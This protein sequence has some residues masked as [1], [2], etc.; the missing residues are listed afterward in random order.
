VL[1]RVHRDP[2][3]VARRV[4]A[5]LHRDVPVRRL[6]KRD[7]EQEDDHLDDDFERFLRVH[8]AFGAALQAPRGR[9]C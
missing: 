8:G 9:G 3:E 1:Q 4:V 2:A 5:A 7:G 6:V